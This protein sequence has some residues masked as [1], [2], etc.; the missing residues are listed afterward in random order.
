MRGLDYR[1]E[2]NYEE[3][4]RLKQNADYTDVTYDEQ[5]G[6]VSAVHRLHKFAKMQGA[7]GMRHG[8]YELAV[9][10]ILRNHGC[11][12]VLEPESNSPG[13]KTCDGYLDDVPMEIKAVEGI[14]T[15]AICT[16]LL[17]AEKQ[18]ARC[19]I[20]YFPEKKLYSTARVEDG[21][22]K[23][24]ANPRLSKERTLN[25]IITICNNEIVA[26]WNKK[27]APIEGRSIWEGFRRE[28]GA[29]SYTLSPSEAKL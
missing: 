13:V 14:G 26:I 3:Y 17:M 2:E 1:R 18:H 9:V 10:S 27:A 6:G 12:I 4:L 22:G 24:M 29:N 25:Q 16:K 15:W 5:S 8:D 20:L 11:L 19:I 7:Y 23:Y 28:N 21:I